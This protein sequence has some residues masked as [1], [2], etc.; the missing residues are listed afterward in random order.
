MRT[1]Y[2][3]WTHENNL[4]QINND[5]YSNNII[6]S[7]IRS[8]RVENSTS[9]SL[10]GLLNS[11]NNNNNIENQG[12]ISLKRVV[13]L[14][15]TIDGA[16][17]TIKS[18][19]FGPS[20]LQMQRSG[21]KEDP[22]SR[23]PTKERF[24]S[25]SD[26]YNKILEAEKEKS[27]EFIKNLITS[28]RNETRNELAAAS[29][30]QLMHNSEQNNLKYTASSANVDNKLL[31]EY[32]KELKRQDLNTAEFSLTGS[33]NF[34]E[35]EKLKMNTLSTM[36]INSQNF[37]EKPRAQSTGNANEIVAAQTNAYQK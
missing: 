31:Q 27:N 16:N 34:E 35:R 10:V 4:F 1:A 26:D 28:I 32:E 13:N 24:D 12:D 36:Q 9:P 18:L 33:M 6:N 15:E 37:D 14:S 11:N 3:K 23:S 25:I 20:S 5:P 8:P 30:N 19:I 7:Q 17:N 29:N 21:K 22:N 2:P